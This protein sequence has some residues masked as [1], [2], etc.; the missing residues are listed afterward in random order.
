MALEIRTNN[1]ASLLASIKKAIDDEKVVTWSYDS[2]NDFTHTAEQWN[3][4]AWLK[5]E[6]DAKNGLLKFTLLKPKN[7]DKIEKAVRG[8]YQGRFIEMLIT[9]FSNSFTIAAAVV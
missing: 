7:V 8:V 5:P 9:H 6:I 1:P 3:E 2:A 4:Q